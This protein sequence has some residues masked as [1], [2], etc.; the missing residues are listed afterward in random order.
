MDQ[1]ELR[2]TIQQAAEKN[3]VIRIR[4]TN[5]KDETQY[6]NVEPY[7]FKGNHVM[8]YCRKKQGIRRFD[9]AQIHSIKVLN[10]SFFPK[11]PVK[12]TADER[13]KTASFMNPWRYR[14]LEPVFGPYNQAD[15]E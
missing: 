6:R 15:V 7:E 4:Y 14:I 9:M 3:K 12:I 5:K 11:W 10:T 1:D 13:E 2:Q 8:A